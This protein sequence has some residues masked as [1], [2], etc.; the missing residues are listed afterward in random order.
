MRLLH[1]DD[2]G[3]LSLTKDFTG[4]IPPY[5]ILSHTWDAEEVTFQDMTEQKGRNKAG[6]NKILFCSRQAKRDGL[7]YFWVD[8]CCIDKSSSAEL[9]EAINSM[10]QWYRNAVHCYA[11]LSDVSTRA[12]SGDTGWRPQFVGS[13][14]F[15]RGWTLQEL[16]APPSV[17]FFSK[18]GDD[19]GNRES[20]QNVIQSITR[21]NMSALCGEKTLDFFSVLERMA[22]SQGR[23]TT[24]AEDAAYC[25][26]G[27]FNV[28]IAVIYGEGAENASFRLRKAI[29]EKIGE[30]PR[31]RKASDGPHVLLPFGQ[32]EDFVE[33]GNILTDLVEKILP[34]T[35]NNDCQRTVLEGLGGVGKTQIALEAAYRVCDR[36]RDC[37]V[38]WVPAITVA[39][40]ENAYREIGRLLGTTGIE[41][42]RADVK[43]MVKTA[44][45]R[46][47]GRWLLVVDNIDNVELLISDGLQKFFPFH[48][49]GSILF[50]TRNHEVA[51]RLG[52]S[53]R[54]TR[55]IE[56]MTEAEALELLQSGLTPR[57]YYDTQATSDLLQR[58][59]YLP[60]A[61]KQA[62]AYMA[63]R[64]VTTATY[65][66]YCLESDEKQIELLN[67]DFEDRWRYSRDTNPITTTWLISFLH[68]EQTY[69][70][71]VDYL[72]FICFLAEKDIPVSFLP[73]GETNAAKD[74]AIGILEGY[75]FISFRERREAF[76]IHRLVRLVTRNWVK[77]EWDI[78]CTKAIQQLN[79]VYPEPKHE[80][81]QTWIGYMPH[82][83]EAL[84]YSQQCTDK[85][86]EASLFFTTA[87]SHEELGK[88][89]EAEG[90][91]RRSLELHTLMCGPTHQDTLASMNN[92]A[93]VLDDLGKYEEAEEM[94][95]EVLELKKSVLGSDHPYT[96]TSMNNLAGV[97][98]S[99]GRYKEAEELH[100]ETLE[101]RISILGPEH[102]RT[103]TSM[104]SLAQVLDDLE[105]FDEA[106]EMLREAVQL[107]MS[108]LGP[109]HPDTL[110]SRN[111]LASVYAKLG[112]YAEAE[113]LHR[114]T[115]ELRISILGPEHPNTLISM[116]NLAVVLD[117]MGRFDEAEKMN[118]EV[119]QLYKSILGPEHPETLISMYN[120]A[121]LLRKSGRYDEAE[122][123]Y[124]YVL[125]YRTR[126]LGPAHPYTLDSSRQ[127]QLLLNARS[128]HCREESSS[129]SE[130]EG[131]VGI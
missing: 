10:F 30:M 74:E 86:A 111:N 88:Y 38:F 37:S 52:A 94:G 119:L 2:D 12:E 118:R 99:L 4:E 96:L 101:L 57:Q 33:R 44:L 89:K 48:Q 17:G 90:M 54:S 1:L 105:R 108:V 129:D 21:I 20:L 9:T 103:L 66:R 42:D 49:K 113:E 11:F 126:T 84:R 53:A 51:V 114:E 83:Q 106:G 55:K 27:I 128:E 46:T 18:E 32:N 78:Y 76:D 19:L 120:L 130:S 16:L 65:L 107:K 91:Y 67:A 24:R 100:R 28:S 97:L 121:Y 112:R 15:T 123:L 110:T 64:G 93:N 79:E 25:L 131:G 6:Y 61:I 50:T 58:L 115:L 34:G 81:R 73:G 117:N 104:D 68:L 36:D 125:E 72:Q 40:F 22:W 41:D 39:T 8:T 122:E 59:V 109:E 71:A 69:P 80:N 56:E 23:Q 5:A 95:R 26:L 62:S 116:D 47:A 77:Q 63:I 60:L 7:A 102:P 43:G 14:W 124:R 3:E 98:K 13:R 87:S 35:K 85:K 127:L 29:E 31:E 70:L 75:A 92:L 82:A 45:E